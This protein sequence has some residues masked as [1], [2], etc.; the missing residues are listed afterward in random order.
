[1]PVVHAEI[2]LLTA[3]IV[4]SSSFLFSKIA[5]ES[6]EPVTLLAIRSLIAFAV[7]AVLFRKRL[8]HIK[9]HTLFHG[10]L[11]GGAFFIVMVFELYGLA[12]TPASVTVFIENTAIAFVPLFSIILTRKLPHISI[13]ISSAA[14]L[15]GVA[16][17]TLK[18]DGFSFTPGELLCFAA[19][20]TYAAA[21]ITTA[22]VTQ[23]EDALAIGILQN[24]FMGLFS[25][26]AAYLMETPSLPSDTTTW[27]CVLVLAL[28]CSVIGFTLQ[29][30]AQ[31]YIDADRAGLFCAISPLSTTILSII[32]LGETLDFHGIIGI[33]F[34]LASLILANIPFRIKPPTT[35]CEVK[36]K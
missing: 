11:L 24:G 12:S 8:L 4:R 29:P 7:L 31:K 15:A 32:F 1:M 6:I 35:P 25:V 17:L 34:I 10:A 33:F 21:I 36:L 3:L 30:I 16:F 27:T 5:L 19:A 13:F 23:E 20:I 26:P 22:R 18:G 28:F 9:R 2:L 14:A